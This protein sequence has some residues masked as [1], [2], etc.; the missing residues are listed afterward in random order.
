MGAAPD[1]PAKRKHKHKTFQPIVLSDT[2]GYSGRYTG[3]DSTYFVDVRVAADGRL[4]VTVHEGSSA[5]VLQDARI[6]GA[7]L[8]GSLLPKGGKP[9]AFQATF[10]RRDING[11]R[12]FGM[13][14]D[15]PVR[16]SG[17]V[18]IER[19]FCARR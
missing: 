1:N 14:T 9:A 7:K 17:D 13:I 16:V 2:R 15:H 3:I 18:V 12:A 8:T 11:R 19:L 4:E 10:G 6:E 5:T